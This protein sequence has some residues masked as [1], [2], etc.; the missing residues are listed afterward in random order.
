MDNSKSPD[1]HHA[2]RS[3][4]KNSP[5]FVHTTGGVTAVEA[6]KKVGFGSRGDQEKGEV[7]QGTSASTAFC[8]ARPGLA[9]TGKRST[10]LASVA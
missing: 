1:P 9:F 3:T 8:T 10:P 2:S 4:T 7:S 6:R 5:A